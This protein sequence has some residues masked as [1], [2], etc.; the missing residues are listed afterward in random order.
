M[1]TKYKSPK[2]GVCLVCS[3]KSKESNVVGIENAYE[4]GYEIGKGMGARS[5]RAL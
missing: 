3:R 5:R 2:A 4:M 1:E